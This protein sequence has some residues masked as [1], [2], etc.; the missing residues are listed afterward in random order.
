MIGWFIGPD[1]GEGSYTNQW[2][3]KFNGN[4]V[5]QYTLNPFQTSELKG[6]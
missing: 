2:M 3:L 4:V 6:E 5:S 1:K